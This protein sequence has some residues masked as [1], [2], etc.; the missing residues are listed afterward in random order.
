MGFVAA[1]GRTGSRNQTQLR[2][3]WIQLLRRGRPKTSSSASALE[4]AESSVP[5]WLP[6]DLGGDPIEYAPQ[7]ELEGF[8]PG[9]GRVGV[10][11]VVED[12]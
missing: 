6:V 7:A 9:L 4:R 8:L 10:N 5:S 2:C 11:V 3:N 1:L 12:P